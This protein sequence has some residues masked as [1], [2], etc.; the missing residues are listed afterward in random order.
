[1]H[2]AHEGAALLSRVQRSSV[3]FALAVCMVGRAGLHSRLSIHGSF[4][5]HQKSNEE[6]QEA[7]A[8]TSQCRNA[9]VPARKLVRHR[10]FY[11]LSPVL[12]RHQGQYGTDG[13]ALVRHCQALLNMDKLSKASGI[14]IYQ[15]LNSGVP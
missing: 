1:M 3:C 8:A 10:N 15:A 11:R 2:I 13:H 9:R 5:A 12:I 14:I 4:L 6:N 7:S